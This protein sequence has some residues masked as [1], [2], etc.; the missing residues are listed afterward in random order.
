MH[1]LVG[2]WWIIWLGLKKSPTSCGYKSSNYKEQQFYQEINHFKYLNFNG[3]ISVILQNVILKE[4]ILIK[5]FK[6]IFANLT[7]TYNFKFIM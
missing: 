7:F 5:R 6:I 2:E 1:I 3:F 4:E